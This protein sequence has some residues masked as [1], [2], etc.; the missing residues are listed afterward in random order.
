MGPDSRKL[1]S[2]VKMTWTPGYVLEVLLRRSG[3]RVRAGQGSGGREGEGREKGVRERGEA[4]G[5]EGEGGGGGGRRGERRYRA[6]CLH[7][8]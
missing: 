8:F 3:G 1:P 5:G 7:D 4:E 2:H 6:C